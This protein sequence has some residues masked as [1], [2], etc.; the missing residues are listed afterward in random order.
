MH[1][2]LLNQFI[3]NNVVFQRYVCFVITVN[4]SF[5]ILYFQPNLEDKSAIDILT[6][7]LNS[8]IDSL[9]R[10]NCLKKSIVKVI[11]FQS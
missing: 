8:T 10:D 5:L 11:V 6:C 3:I 7:L 4:L 9:L 1:C 2:I